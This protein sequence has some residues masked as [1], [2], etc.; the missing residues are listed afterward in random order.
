MALYFN[1][2][3]PDPMQHATPYQ[4]HCPN[5]PWPSM[6]S[7]LSP[8]EHICDE[9][10]RCVR[11]RVSA[12]VIVRELFQALQQEWVAILMWV[13][14]SLISPC[15]RDAEQLLILEQETPPC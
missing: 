13:I 15:L 7:D 2:T 1:M 14:H 3:V 4:Q 9:V 6:S 11:G 5:S 12:P 8:V 10:G